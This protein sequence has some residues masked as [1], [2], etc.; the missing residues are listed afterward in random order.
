M[1][2]IW[3]NVSPP[4]SGGV[5]D[6]PSGGEGEVVCLNFTELRFNQLNN[7]FRIL[8]NKPV[9]DSYSLNA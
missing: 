9:L 2:R 6:P 5:P 4:E 7:K 3:Y 8:K 1:I